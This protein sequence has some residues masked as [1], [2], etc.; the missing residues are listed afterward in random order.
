MARNSAVIL[1]FT[2][3]K[4]CLISPGTDLPGEWALLALGSF[5]GLLRY[6]LFSISLTHGLNV[7][8][9]HE[10]PAHAILP[11]HSE[12][13]AQFLRAVELQVLLGAVL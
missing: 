3:T 2:G 8:R 13:K 10:V 12:R 4:V 9:G 1:H 11:L 7:P 6:N 5:P